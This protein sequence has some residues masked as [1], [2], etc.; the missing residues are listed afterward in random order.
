M[1]GVR[2]YAK[3]LM[4]DLIVDTLGAFA[5]SMFGWW[6]MKKGQRSFIENWIQKFIN[7]NE[8]FFSRKKSVHK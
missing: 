3:V 5:I 4:W 8:R 6:Y 2:D 1:E 7:K